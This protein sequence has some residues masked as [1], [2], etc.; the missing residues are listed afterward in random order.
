MRQKPIP[1]RAVLLLIAIAMVMP[2][3]ICVIL[4]LGRLLQAM[5]DAS[6]S[7]VLDWIA[8]A[9]GVVWVLDLICLILAHSINSLAELD[10]D[11]SANAE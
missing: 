1:K 2:I 9:C 5:G 3:G 6:G 8:L 7:V 10:D 11:D 4:A